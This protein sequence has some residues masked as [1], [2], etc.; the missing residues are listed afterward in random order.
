MAKE[1]I[2]KELAGKLRALIESG[3]YAA[4]DSFLSMREIG[5][6]YDVTPS[7]ALAAVSHLEQQG[8]LYVE[9]GKGSFV[10]PRISTRNIL[11]VAD[12]TSYRSGAMP[13]FRDGLWEALEG[14][15]A[16]S[17][18]FTGRSRTLR[19]RPRGSSSVT[20]GQCLDHRPTVDAGSQSCALSQE[21][22]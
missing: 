7:T 14:H 8:L 3:S 11:L 22:E 21:A 2:H 18:I 20:L 12:S 10:A 19:S 16:R 1:V 4:H 5:R 6:K 13:I 9:H 17:R 15:F